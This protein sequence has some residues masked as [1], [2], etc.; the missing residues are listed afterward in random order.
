MCGK[1]TSK[2]IDNKKHHYDN[3]AFIHVRFFIDK[4]NFISFN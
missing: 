1:N 4:K 2:Q 3:G